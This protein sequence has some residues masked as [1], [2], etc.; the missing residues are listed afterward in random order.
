MIA[1]LLA[2]FLLGMRHG[3]DPDHLA[4]VD[5]LTRRVALTQPAA[6]KFVG[7]LFAGG[8]TVMVLGIAALLATAGRYFETLGSGLERAGA[9]VSVALLI[10]MAAINLR[11]LLRTQDAAPAGIRVRMLRPLLGQ[12]RSAL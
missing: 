2:V 8:H 12:S 3:A 7:T 6:G 5:N 11:R 4:A 10:A 9:W 1:S